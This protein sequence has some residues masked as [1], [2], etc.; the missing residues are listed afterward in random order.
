MS[1]T[2]NGSLTPT[3]NT[4]KPGDWC[5]LIID[6]DF[7]KYRLA[8]TLEPR[9]DILLRKI[10][11]FKVTVPDNPSFP[12]QVDLTLIHEWEIDKVGE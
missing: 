6:D 5:V 11:G 2:V 12:E 1:V 4:Y 9:S 10:E 8:T 3:I 7:V